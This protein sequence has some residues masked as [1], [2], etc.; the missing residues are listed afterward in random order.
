VASSVL[1]GLTPEPIVIIDFSLICWRV[2][3]ISL[4]VVLMA[5]KYVSLD[6]WSPTSGL[7]P[8]QGREGSDVE[9]LEGFMEKSIIMKKSKFV[10]LNS[11]NDRDNVSTESAFINFKHAGA[12]KF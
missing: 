3:R 12:I 8:H 7:D 9:S 11:N 5:T 4:C 1:H 10:Y 2:I 6:H